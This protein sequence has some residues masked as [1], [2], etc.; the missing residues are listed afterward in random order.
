M[1]R[2]SKSYH[3][4]MSFLSKLI[5]FRKMATQMYTFI[6]VDFSARRVNGS[7]QYFSELFFVNNFSIFKI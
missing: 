6:S 3:R 7:L 1:L 5:T 2:I 4:E